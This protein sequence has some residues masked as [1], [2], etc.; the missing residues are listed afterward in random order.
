MIPIITQCGKYVSY[1]AGKPSNRFRTEQRRH[2]RNNA[3]YY[4]LFAENSLATYS[5]F[6]EDSLIFIPIA[7]R[8]I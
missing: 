1:D 4:G 6:T 2:S 3:V 8:Q 7:I 5:N